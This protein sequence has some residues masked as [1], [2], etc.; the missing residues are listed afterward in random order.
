MAALKVSLKY[1]YLHLIIQTSQFYMGSWYKLL[2]SNC[3][4]LH[5]F[6]WMK[7]LRW[8]CSRLLHNHGFL[9]C[10]KFQCLKFRYT[11]VVNKKLFWVFLK[12]TV[13]SD[14]YE[15]VLL[16]K[17]GQ[18]EKLVENKKNKKCL[19]QK[20]KSLCSLFMDE[21]QLSQVYRA[22]M[23]RQFTFYQSVPW[24]SWYSFNQLWKVERLIWTWSHSL[25]LNLGPLEWESSPLTAI[26]SG[27]CLYYMGHFTF[28]RVE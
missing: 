14:I 7:I 8:Q 11:E 15:H 12:C 13:V 16:K 9:L 4:F 23:R 20:L 1:P 6:P 21:V 26:K 19:Q 3:Y 17:A 2:K 25:I 10:K 28:N 27:Q 24:S 18:L 22:T 5:N